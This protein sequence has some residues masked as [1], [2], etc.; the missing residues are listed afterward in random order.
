MTKEVHSMHKNLLMGFG[1]LVLGLAL[2]A[3][4]ARAV[5][6]Q[7]TQVAQAD[8]GSEQKAPKTTK[9]HTKKKHT[10]KKHKAQ[11]GK[12]GTEAQPK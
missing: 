12:T 6:H 7:A 2:A 10:K 8:T 11:E 3:P 4:A 5:T 1:T 9:K